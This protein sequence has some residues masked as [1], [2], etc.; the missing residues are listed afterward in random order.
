MR[1]TSISSND[2]DNFFEHQF[3][4]PEVVMVTKVLRNQVVIDPNFPGR[5]TKF[6]FKGW[7][8]K[9]LILLYLCC[10]IQPSDI[11]WYAR[12]DIEEE[13]NKLSYEDRLIFEL[14]KDIRS[15]NE[16]LRFLRDTNEWS[17]RSF[18][19]WFKQQLPVVLKKFNSCIYVQEPGPV[20]QPQRKRGYNDKGSRTLPHNNR[21]TGDDF[22]FIE[23]Q[24]RIERQRKLLSDTT[25]LLRGMFLG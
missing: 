3:E 7:S 6:R 4:R 14:L 11:F 5:Q 23:R 19:G 24:Q 1:E 2:I 20:C 13:A 22:S 16:L 8:R 21:N 10:L 25:A 15:Y 18:F 17:S 12:L 9:E